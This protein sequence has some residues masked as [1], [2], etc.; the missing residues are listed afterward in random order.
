M[1]E[2]GKRSTLHDLGTSLVSF[3]IK[4]KICVTLQVDIIHS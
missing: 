4:I 1:N 2:G 3:G